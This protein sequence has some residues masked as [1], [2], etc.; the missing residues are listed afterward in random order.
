M[1][2][3][4]LQIPA[5]LTQSAARF[6][7]LGRVAGA[8]WF[9]LLAAFYG[10]GLLSA[11]LDL[12]PAPLDF[13]QWAPLLSSGCTLVFFL[14]LTWLMLVRPVAAA[15]RTEWIP[16]T[17]SLLGTYGVW[18][19]GFLPQAPFSPAVSI[20]AAAVTLV[21]S[22]LI[23]YTIIH[24]GR[25]FSISPQARVLVTH[26]PYALVRHPL[27]AAEEIAL[28][29]VAMH[30]VWWGAVPFLLAHLALQIRRMT[31]EEGLLSSVFP[32]Y[33]DYAKRTARLIPGVW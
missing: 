1:T 33:A 2:L 27:Y 20:S 32:E 5:S 3:T 13:A 25:S 30:V 17:V 24:L 31:Y 23:V 11:L 6:P 16:R 9:F 26:G 21:G 18:T 19:V 22:I 15:R 8:V 28:V 4:L 29:G 14:T 7:R 10:R 12:P